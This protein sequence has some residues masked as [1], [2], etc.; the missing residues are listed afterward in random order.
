[1]EY[2]KDL[3]VGYKQ[4]DLILKQ[5]QKLKLIKFTFLE[6]IKIQKK[7]YNKKREKMIQARKL[8][9]T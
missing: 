8:V 9:N 5:K 6:S 1:M 7:N 4:P 2:I 3:L